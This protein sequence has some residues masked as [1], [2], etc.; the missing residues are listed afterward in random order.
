M[1]ASASSKLDRAGIVEAAIRVADREGLAAVSMRR[2]G[3]DLGYSGMSL[4]GYVAGKEELLDLMAD[5][6]LGEVQELDRDAPW[7]PAIVDFFASLH[8]VLLRHPAVAQ[9]F[10]TRPTAGPN[11][12]RHAEEAL[13]VLTGG[14][15]S[16]ER[17][18]EAFIALSCYT[19]GAALYSAARTEPA[20]QWIGARAGPDQFRSGLEH[21]VRG[22]A[23]DVS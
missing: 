16:E 2:I 6:V 12:V 19:L 11:T 4:Y 8:D 7:Q 20:A 22:Y 23:T 10:T 5:Q 15:L 21:L 14:G 1:S 3:A 17:A 13:A 9:V 18:L